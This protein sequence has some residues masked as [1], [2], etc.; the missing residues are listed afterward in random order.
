MIVYCFI[1]FLAGI[2]DSVN[3]QICANGE[4]TTLQAA[5]EKARLLMTI[6]DHS[7]P[8]AAVSPDDKLM[9]ELKEQVTQLIEQV[10]ACTVYSETTI[11]KIL[12]SMQS[13]WP[14]TKGLP[15]VEEPAPTSGGHDA[16]SFAN[17][18]GH[19]TRN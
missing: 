2:A 6:S 11:S 10:T 18:P 9:G 4:V 15:R 16:V 5:V 19:I 1:I 8:I 12:L 17:R 13:T 14:P 7:K 3:T